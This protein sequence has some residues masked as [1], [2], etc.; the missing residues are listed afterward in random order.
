VSGISTL[1]F[2]L[3]LI[4]CIVAIITM[5]GHRMP[6]L[7][8]FPAIAFAIIWSLVAIAYDVVVAAL[9]ED[10]YLRIALACVLLFFHNWMLVLIYIALVV[11]LLDRQTAIRTK[12]NGA[13]GENPV[14]VV[15][16]VGLAMFA[17]ATAQASA[18]VNVRLMAARG[19]SK[20][21]P[22]EYFRRIY[23]TVALDNAFYAVVIV[24]TVDVIVTAIILSEAASISDKVC[25]TT[26][27]RSLETDTPFV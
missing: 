1:L 7:V 25:G 8:L 15:V 3:Q 14:L 18:S 24:S 17:L 12:S 4:H 10:V 2:V 19:L 11:F 9:A 23:T 5:R 26:H 27:V 22:Q 13:S 20:S 16:H 21:D 6:F